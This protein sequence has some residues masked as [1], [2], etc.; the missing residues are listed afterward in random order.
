M[1]KTLWP[2]PFNLQSVSILWICSHGYRVLSSVMPPDWGTNGIINPIKLIDLC[3]VYSTQGGCS[4]VEYLPKRCSCQPWLP[5]D[6]KIGLVPVPLLTVAAP[7]SLRT[8]LAAAFACSWL[9]RVP[10]AYCEG[11][12]T[13]CGRPQWI[14]KD[15]QPLVLGL[16]G[17][18]SHPAYPVK[19]FLV[20]GWLLESCEEHMCLELDGWMEGRVALHLLPA[21]SLDSHRGGLSPRHTCLYPVPRDW[22]SLLHT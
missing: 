1:W 17:R 18:S 11:A 16:L 10:G 20:R 4:G 14:V 19:L 12:N 22:R 3:S 5:V 21:T 7:S 13:V 9:P 6:A 2:W 15:R 8:M